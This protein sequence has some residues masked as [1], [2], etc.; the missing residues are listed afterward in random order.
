M[1]FTSYS[2][3]KTKVAS[4]LARSDL[5]DQI[6]DFIRLAE[7]RLNRELRTR[8]ML[9]IATTDTSDA[10]VGLPSDFLEMRDIHLVTN[11]IASLDYKTPNAFYKDAYATQS[12][13]PRTY[14]VLS[15]EF[16]LAPSPDSQYTLQ[17][18]YY[19]KPDYLSDTNSSNIWLANCPDALLYGALGEAEPYLMN[20]A[21]L[22]TWAAMYD[23][24]INT[25]NVA[26][27]SSEHSGQ[28]ISMT[29]NV[30]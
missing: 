3:L 11:P 7:L 10:L 5:T 14:T 20:D 6:P 4:Y 17:M 12:G 24:A 19:A 16:Q 27:H 23:R 9:K 8:Q 15:T 29:Y 13:K 1:A 25:I 18:L 28:P 22:A 2:D 21:R 26:D 30:R